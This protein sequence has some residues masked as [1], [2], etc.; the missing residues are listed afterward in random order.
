MD[1]TEIQGNPIE[2]LTEG[3]EVRCIV[4]I[5]DFRE[6]RV[7]GPLVIANENRNQ[8]LIKLNFVT[9]AKAANVT[10]YKR[11]F[12]KREGEGLVWIEPSNRD[13]AAPQLFATR[14]QFVQA[15]ENGAPRIIK[16]PQGAR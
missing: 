16:P 3:T 14:E 9:L 6:Q 8:P 15:L 7:E 4:P 2:L 1:E 5:N 11:A 12:C 10:T 13:M